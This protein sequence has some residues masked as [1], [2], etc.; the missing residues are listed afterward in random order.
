MDYQAKVTWTIKTREITPK[1]T[2]T[3][4]NAIRIKKGKISNKQFQLIFSILKV[5]LRSTFKDE[6]IKKGLNIPQIPI[7]RA[8]FLMVYN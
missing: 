1:F 5:P 8:L 6:N 7:F 3:T 2:W 4:R